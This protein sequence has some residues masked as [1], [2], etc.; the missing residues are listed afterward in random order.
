MMTVPEALLIAIAGAFLVA[1]GLTALAVSSLRG[2][3]RDR[4]APLFGVFVLLYGVRLL[5]RSPRVWEATGLA[6][7][8]FRFADNWITYSILAPATMFVEAI[9]APA[10]RTRI[11]RRRA[12]D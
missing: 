1:I 4:A 7:T 10:Y 9:A 3:S 8:W 12:G 2:L 6:E 11:F 5:C